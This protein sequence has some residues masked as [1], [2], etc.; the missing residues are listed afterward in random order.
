[1][2]TNGRV[3]LPPT[4]DVVHVQVG[5]QLGRHAVPDPVLAFLLPALLVPQVLTVLVRHV[6]ASAV[7]LALDVVVLFFP[8]PMVVFP[9]GI[10][11]LHPVYFYLT[12]SLLLIPRHKATHLMVMKPLSSLNLQ[13]IGEEKKRRMGCG[14]GLTCRCAPRDRSS[15]RGPRRSRP[16]ATAPALARRRSSP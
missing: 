2:A 13:V 14:V 11:L 4:E 3:G 16:T 10:N 6:V 1:M 5:L 12:S 8:G 9:P 7:A 15:D